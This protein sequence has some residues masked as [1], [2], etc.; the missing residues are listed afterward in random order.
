MKKK[1]IA[2]FI[3][4]YVAENSIVFVF[5]SEIASKMWQEE[6]LDFHPEGILPDE[7]FIA[8]DQFKRE[9]AEK[10]RPGYTDVPECARDFYVEKLLLRNENEA[11]LNKKPLLT[12]IVP[13][14]FAGDSR[15][16]SSWI[17]NILPELEFWSEK[18]SMPPHNLKYIPK[19][20]DSDDEK[21]DLDFIKNDYR[22]FLEEHK[23]FESSWGR[24]FENQSGKKYIIL[25]FEAIE[26]FAGY[27]SALHP[28]FLSL[29]DKQF[30][31][32]SALQEKTAVS[33]PSIAFFTPTI[34]FHENFREEFKHIALEIEKLLME[35]EKSGDIAVSLNNMENNAPYFMREL[36]IRGIPAVL[37]AG[38]I[39]GKGRVGKIFSLIQQC[40]AENFS[41]RTLKNL[42]Y[43][44][45]L[46]W[47]SSDLPVKLIRFGIENH[48][49]S[50]WQEKG[51][52]TAIDVWESAFKIQ[53][54]RQDARLEDWYKKLKKSLKAIASARN[55]SSLRAAWFIFRNDFIDVQKIR[56]DD[57]RELARCIEELTEIAEL[58]K[59]Y[60]EYIPADP[61]SFL[62]NRLNKKIYVPKNT[63]GGINVFP[64]RVAAG[65]PFKFHFIA[66]VSQE[67][68]TVLYQQ[69]KF[70]RKD[71]RE[72]LLALETDASEIF[73]SLYL[74]G[75]GNVF[76][77]SSHRAVDGYKTPHN[78]F[79]KPEN[80]ENKKNEN[81]SEENFFLEDPYQLEES[82]MKPSR[83]Y[84]VQKSGFIF[85][86]AQVSEEQFSFLREPFDGNRCPETITAVKARL[87]KTQV[88]EENN[89]RVSSKDL[90]SFSD[91]PAKWFMEKTAGLKRGVFSA[92]LIDERQLGLIF[93]SVL[94]NVYSFIRETD[95]VFLSSRLN[96]YIQ[97]AEYFAKTAASENIDFKGPLTA[98]IISTLTS[99]IMEG[100]TAVLKEDAEK[101]DNFEPV[102][103]EGKLSF[104]SGGKEFFGIID[105]I[106]ISG[107]SGEPVLIDYKSGS[108]FPRA[109]DYKVENGTMAD[110]QI[111]LY[112][113]LS[114]NSEAS[115]APG[116]QITQAWIFSIK[117]QKYIPVLNSKDDQEFSD[118]F[119]SRVRSFSSLEDFKP[120]MDALEKTADNFRQA[121]ENCDFTSGNFD[122]NRCY[123]CDFKEIC[124]MT[125]AVKP[126]RSE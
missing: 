1:L 61:L 89:V 114:E 95:K 30:P 121:V 60:P 23:I 124:R 6:A 57:N 106:S 87:K 29:T 123:S 110:Y 43:L 111:P 27:S 3:K 56:E 2:D 45:T 47:K 51:Q 39:L 59:E 18:T 40:S 103:L 53:K 93:H 8:W 49:V 100:V 71:K 90:A 62:V 15:I 10:A 98:P 83:I 76:F 107:C 92:E 70:L 104:K 24:C 31:E 74:C 36:S 63:L 13:A 102:L 85:Y 69:L 28:A 75:G 117:Q 37:R 42:L 84:P 17:S 119:N 14:E 58:E 35:G 88:T 48:C 115:P 97:K 9:C 34:R 41:F 80:L 125:Y 112:I 126:N 66:G 64:Y 77:S 82:G 32:P 50:S 105:R 12:S 101:L 33:L 73:F 11:R 46:P 22:K 55:F 26:D 20:K 25:F 19:R 116:R 91:C 108:F 72:Q 44:K 78:A 4:K 38:Y 109:S 65:T 7:R 99:R 52:N 5:P 68:S 21:K 113:L 79:Y 120:S 86:R 94:K 96:T 81:E 118:S 67:D 16:F 54:T 122:W